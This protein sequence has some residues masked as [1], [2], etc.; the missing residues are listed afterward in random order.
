MAKGQ[1]ARASG[2]ER[3]AICSCVTQAILFG[4]LDPGDGAE[5]SQEAE[6]RYLPLSFFR[7][8]S[9]FDILLISQILLF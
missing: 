3:M 9:V 7:G 8:H 6:G 4:P 2:L 5:V 1:G